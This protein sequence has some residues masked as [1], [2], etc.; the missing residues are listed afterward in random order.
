MNDH[1]SNRCSYTHIGILGSA[2]FFFAAFSVYKN[3]SVSLMSLPKKLWEVF[4]KT[5]EYSAMCSLIVVLITVIG[6]GLDLAFVVNPA[7]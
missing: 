6:I 2:E 1:V 4:C 7:F 3:D 5:C